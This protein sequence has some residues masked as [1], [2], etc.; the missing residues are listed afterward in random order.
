MIQERDRI[1]P[2]G[3]SWNDLIQHS[4]SDLLEVYSRILR[5]LAKERG[6]LGD[7][8]AQSMSRFNNPINLKKLLNLINAIEWT[9]LDTDIKAAAYEGLLEKYAAEEKGAGQYFTPRSLIRSIVRCVKPDFRT[10][11][12]FTIHDPAC[13]TGGFLIGAFEWIMKETHA[14][15]RL[16]TEDRERLIKQTLS[17]MDNVQST[18]R[19]A[20]MNCYLHELEPKIYFGDALGEGAHVNERY[21]V[22]LTNPPF[23]TR[24]ATGVPARDD[25]LVSTSNKQLNFM[26]HV[27]TLLKIGGHSAMIVPD[28]VLFDNAGKPIRKN[29]LKSCNLHT[30]LRLPLGTFSPYSAGV[31]ANVIFFIK[32]SPTKE[33]WIYDL[34]TNINNINKG[35]PL[36]EEL[37]QDFEISYSKKPRE[38]SERFRSFSINDIESE[39]YNLDITWLTD[40]TLKDRITLPPPHVIAAETVS[41]LK[42]ALKSLENLITETPQKK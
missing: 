15:S 39:D 36:K 38:S 32:G 25:F 6:M 26:Q 3:C 42:I 29:L 21:N 19:L 23:G 18:R 34:R 22:I 11:P 40:S 9:S 31:K 13:G 5:R 1:I 33:T 2:S 16:T 20:L 41:N 17:G 10:S 7:I 8:F 12:N 27:I 14:G 37:F 35:N 30:I 24:G 28:N 4:G